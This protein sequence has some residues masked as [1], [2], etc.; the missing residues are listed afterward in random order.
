[1]FLTDGVEVFVVKHGRQNDFATEC[2]AAKEPMSGRHTYY[3]PV[4]DGEEYSVGVLFGKTFE[5]S[6]ATINQQL[7]RK[8]SA[9]RIKVTIDKGI[10][11]EERV[12]KLPDLETR[13]CL[14]EFNVFYSASNTKSGSIRRYRPHFAEVAKGKHASAAKTFYHN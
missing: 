7:D 11:L 2:V 13:P 9:C 10:A 14:Q 4:G 6:P 5:I 12:F 8:V 1:M 3:M